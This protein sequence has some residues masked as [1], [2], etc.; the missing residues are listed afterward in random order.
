MKTPVLIVRPD[1]SFRDWPRLDILLVPGGIGTRT[2]MKDAETLEF[3]KRNVSP[4][5]SCYQLV[6]ER[7]FS[8]LQVF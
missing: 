7:W 4:A 6:P 5:N 2:E 8:R 1:Y 3:A